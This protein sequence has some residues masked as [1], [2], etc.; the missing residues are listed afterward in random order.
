MNNGGWLTNFLQGIIAQG[1]FLI[2]FGRTHMYYAG[3]IAQLR[4]AIKARAP[5]V[6]AECWELKDREVAPLQYL[7]WM[8]DEVEK[9]DT[10]SEDDAA[11]AGRW[12]GWVAAHAELHGLWDNQRFRE[13]IRADVQNN[14]HKPHS[15]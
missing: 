13:L 4:R 15:S 6:L 7:L 3:C 5:R 12:I 9:M 10:T 1:S 2:S 14:F 11:K 8:C